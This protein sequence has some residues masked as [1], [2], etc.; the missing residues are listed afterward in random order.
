MGEEVAA[1]WGVHVIIKKNHTDL[2]LFA[3]KLTQ[4]DMIKPSSYNVT[5]LDN[6]LHEDDDD[7]WIRI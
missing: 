2:L 6:H 5:H 4:T 1:V 3:A 7:E